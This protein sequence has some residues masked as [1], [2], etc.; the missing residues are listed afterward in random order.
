VFLFLDKLPIYTHHQKNLF[1]D[2]LNPINQEKKNLKVK[3][4]EGRKV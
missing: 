3:L 2:I 4:T 1:F